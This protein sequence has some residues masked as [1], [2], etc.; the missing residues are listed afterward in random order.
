MTRLKGV[1]HLPDEWVVINR[2]GTDTGIS[3]TAYRRDSRLEVFSD[4]LDWGEFEQRLLEC[5]VR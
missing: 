3:P 5:I 1:F 2:T 4:T